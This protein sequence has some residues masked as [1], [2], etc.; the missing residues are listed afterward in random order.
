MSFAKP[1]KKESDSGPSLMCSARGCPL[2]WS[3]KT[4]GTLC[5]YHAWDDPIQWP[6]ITDRLLQFGP[7][8]RPKGPESVTV[9]E[10]KA[11]MRSGF[12]FTTLTEKIA[13]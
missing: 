1:E 9:R 10:M 5:S 13:A 12:R 7:W 11:Q 2:K 3:V 8:K 4:D 6:S